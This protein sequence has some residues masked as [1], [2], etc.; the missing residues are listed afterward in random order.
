MEEFKKIFIEEMKDVLKEGYK[1]EFHT[2]WYSCE[3]VLVAK[4]TF[5]DEEC[6]NSYFFKKYIEE[7][8]KH[9]KEVADCIKRSII[10]KKR[11]YYLKTLN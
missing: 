9:P 3:E 4:I 2:S 8:V 5:A 11:E 10:R 7:F 1:I 6:L